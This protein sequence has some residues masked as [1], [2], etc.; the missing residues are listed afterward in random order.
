MYAHTCHIF[1]YKK[2]VYLSHFNEF[3]TT[4]RSD[5]LFCLHSIAFGCI[6]EAMTCIKR[7]F[8]F[9]NSS[10][11]YY[12]DDVN[13]LCAEETQKKILYISPVHR[14]WI[15]FGVLFPLAIFSVVLLRFMNEYQ[16][17]LHA[18]ATNTSTSESCFS[19]HIKKKC[20]EILNSYRCCIFRM[21]A[22]KKHTQRV[23]NKGNNSL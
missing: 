19:S 16:Q 20:M 11:I 22:G 17:R 15:S 21:H 7:G 2:N 4:R 8:K 13:R 23:N 3:C 18:E 10:F 6:S 5:I 1:V 9:R 14:I 12:F